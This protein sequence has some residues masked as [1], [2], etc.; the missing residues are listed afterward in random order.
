MLA[1]LSKN[2]ILRTPPDFWAGA[3]CIVNRQISNDPVVA[4]ALG[5]HCMT[6]DLPL[7]QLPFQ[8]PFVFTC[9]CEPTGPRSARPEDRLREAI[10]GR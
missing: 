4:M 9:H 1:G 6:L 5:R 10:S 3:G 7:P 8:L 2:E